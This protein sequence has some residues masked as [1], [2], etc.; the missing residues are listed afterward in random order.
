MIVVDTHALLWL[1]SAVGNLGP[2]TRQT[3]DRALR[4]DDLAVSAMTFW[5]VAMLRDKNRI[6][7]PEDVG[8]WRRELLSQGIIEIPV[9]GEIGIRANTLP[10]FHP[11]P[12]DRIIV[13]TAIDGHQLI[14]GDTAIL[15]WPVTTEDFSHMI[16]TPEFVIC[17]S[18]DFPRVA[19][20]PPIP[21][22]EFRSGDRQP[23]S[24]STLEANLVSRSSC[25]TNIEVEPTNYVYG[26]SSY[27]RPVTNAIV[28]G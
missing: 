19:I 23:F 16:E 11:D 25:V 5:E 26:G 2:T 8:L 7:F 20:N 1:W 18:T 12:A 24:N 6:D 28:Y 17:G 9:D 4:E 10:D 13:A 15:N 21:T 3:I 14:T 22:L 27:K